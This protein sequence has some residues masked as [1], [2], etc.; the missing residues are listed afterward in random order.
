MAPCSVAQLQVS[1]MVQPIPSGS[2]KTGGPEETERPG[3][4]WP[5]VTT[6]TTNPPQGCRGWEDIPVTQWVLPT[7]GSAASQRGGGG[8][9]GRAGYPG[10]W[11]A[12][13]CL[14]V[15]GPGIPDQQLWLSLW[16]AK[17]RPPFCKGFH[18]RLGPARVRQAGGLVLS[19]DLGTS[20]QEA[21][22]DPGG[23]GTISK[24]G[25]KMLYQWALVP[26]PGWGCI[27]KQKMPGKS[28]QLFKNRLRS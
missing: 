9:E 24:A 4:E 20:S 10:K 27:R 6:T 26:G 17:V 13:E 2:K 22:R 15:V 16:L 5:Q 25:F 11:V 7:Q 28:E 12:G 23:L 19:T 1:G 8:E 18:S 3:T 21:A 14:H